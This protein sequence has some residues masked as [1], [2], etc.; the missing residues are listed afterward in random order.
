M[1]AA[2]PVTVDYQP[3]CLTPSPISMSFATI[4]DA[5]V[6][7]KVLAAGSGAFSRAIDLAGPGPRSYFTMTATLLGADVDQF[8]RDEEDAGRIKTGE[9]YAEVRTLYDVAM[10]RTLSFLFPDQKTGA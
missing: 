1:N 7:A 4:R 3:E 2:L 9:D 5:E 8:L 10:R 6:F